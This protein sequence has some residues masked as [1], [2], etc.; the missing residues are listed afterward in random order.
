MECCNG[1]LSLQTA[2]YF[3]GDI[4]VNIIYN[5]FTY[6]ILH[7]ISLKAKSGNISF[8]RNE[9]KLVPNVKWDVCLYR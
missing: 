6:T 3:K 1:F 8:I 2:S 5:I 4:H 9:Y 7:G